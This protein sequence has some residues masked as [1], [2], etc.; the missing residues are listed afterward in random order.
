MQIKSSQ[1]EGIQLVKGC[2]SMQLCFKEIKEKLHKDMMVEFNICPVEEHNFN[3]KVERK[4][5]QIKESLEK[6]VLNQRLS[7]LQQETVAAE[8]FNVIN[9]LRLALGNLVSDFENMALIT[10]NRLRLRRN[11]D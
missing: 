7:V 5:C 8:I 2:Q 10:P 11:N 1:V 4:I 3:G 6:N 9:D